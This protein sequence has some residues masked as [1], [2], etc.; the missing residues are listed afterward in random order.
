MK[1]RF[2]LTL[3]G[4]SGATLLLSSPQ[5]ARGYL[6]A[7][8]LALIHAV[9]QHMFPEGTTMPSAKS[10]NATEFLN[11]TVSHSSFDKDIRKFIIDG[12][13]KLQKREESRFLHYSSRER[14]RALRSYEETPFGSGWLDR[15]MLLSLEGLLSDPIYGGNSKQSGWRALATRGGEPRPTSRYIEL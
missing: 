12:S 7:D 8:T 14:E 5:K 10:F 13:E 3:L 15:I 11:E 1:R 2:F 9:Q 6:S 4:A